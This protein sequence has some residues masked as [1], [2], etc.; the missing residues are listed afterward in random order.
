MEKTFHFDS[1]EHP[2]V[3]EAAVLCCFDQRIRLAV[4]KFLQ[5]IGISHPD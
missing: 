4:S 5:R 2:Y 1:E 3:A